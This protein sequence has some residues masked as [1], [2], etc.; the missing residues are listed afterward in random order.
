MLSSTSVLI[1]DSI[2]YFNLR[3][4]GAKGLCSVIKKPVRFSGCENGD[5]PLGLPR[6]IQVPCGAAGLRLACSL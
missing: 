3:Q 6:T 1:I 2:F 4:F 5:Y